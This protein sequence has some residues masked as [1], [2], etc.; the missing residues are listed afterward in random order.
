ML[1]I[2]NVGFSVKFSVKGISGIVEQLCAP[3]LHFPVQLCCMPV[4][5]LLHYG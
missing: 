1:E 3:T 2:P 5:S 4:L